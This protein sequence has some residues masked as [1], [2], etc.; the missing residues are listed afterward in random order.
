LSHTH[1]VDPEPATPRK[2]PALLPS[3]ER[4]L[5]GCELAGAR[6]EATAFDG[7]AG[8]ATALDRVADLPAPSSH[9]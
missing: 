1:L 2:P 8:S 6:W 9:P 4:V 5:I 3:L 7:G